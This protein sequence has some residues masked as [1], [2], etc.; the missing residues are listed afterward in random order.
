MVLLFQ[1]NTHQITIGPATEVRLSSP[2]GTVYRL[3]AAD[4]GTLGTEAV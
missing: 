2:N 1:N 3:T 4:D